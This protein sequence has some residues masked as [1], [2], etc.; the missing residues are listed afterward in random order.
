MTFRPPRGNLGKK[1]TLKY[2]SE[3]CSYKHYNCTQPC[4]ENYS[5]C[6]RHILDDKTAPFKQCNYFY[7]VTGRRCPLPAPKNER[8]E[9]YCS[10]HARKVQLRQHKH[11]GTSLPPLTAE[12]L[13][14]SIS[15]YV[16][17]PD[18]GKNNTGNKSQEEE[19]NGENTSSAQEITSDASDRD[20]VL[21][22]K[23]L[24]PFVDINASTVNNSLHKV[25]EYCSESDSDV[26]VTTVEHTARLVFEIAKDKGQ[27]T[28]L[29]KKYIQ[30]KNT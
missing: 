22:T 1:L 13:L 18:D 4:L 6:V 2:S 26:D 17:L 21:I 10:E 15:H 25:L 7:T 29:F 3:P 5:L 19:K 28:K 16:K 30:T 23:C 14:S 11:R 8:R 24:N 27:N 20:N 12:R 9:S